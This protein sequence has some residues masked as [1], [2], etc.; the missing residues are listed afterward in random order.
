MAEGKVGYLNQAP[1]PMSPSEDLLTLMSEAGVGSKRARHAAMY[2]KMSVAQAEELFRLAQRRARQIFHDPPISVRPGADVFPF[3]SAASP[4][5]VA[6][7]TSCS[8][9]R[10]CCGA[11]LN[12]GSGSR[13]RRL[14][15]TAAALRQ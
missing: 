7:V 10:W 13:P 8:L 14:P 1:V 9:P 3:Y 11:S 12:L 2:A 5:H 6:L 4:V 15:G